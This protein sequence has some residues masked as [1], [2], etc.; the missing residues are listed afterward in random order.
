[1]AAWL[2]VVTSAA[3]PGGESLDDVARRMRSGADALVEACPDGRVLVVSHK[4]PIRALICSALDLPLPALRRF[5]VEMASVSR[6][7]W[8]KSQYFLKYL[9]LQS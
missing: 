2:A 7:D 6:L 5:D 3:T 9:S 4:D 8:A 1:M